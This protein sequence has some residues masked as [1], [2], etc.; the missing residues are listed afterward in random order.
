MEN[1]GIMHMIMPRGPLYDLRVEMVVQITRSFTWP[2][3][4][5]IKYHPYLCKLYEGV[6]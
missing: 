3:L 6:K 1:S 2:I 5:L 4:T